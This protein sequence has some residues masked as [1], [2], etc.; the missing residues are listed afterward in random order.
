[1]EAWPGSP[2]PLGA[3]FDGA[4]TNFAIYSE[5]ADAIDLCLLD[6]L[7][8]ETR[9]PLADR[10]THVFHAYLPAVMPGQRYGFRVH[11]PNDP[12]MGHHC[13]P[14]R[15]LVDPYAKAIDAGRR[16][17]V[18][19]PFFDWGH[20]RPP[21]TPW[22]ETVIYELHVKGFT[23]LHPEVPEPLRGSYAGLGH[24]SVVEYLQKLGVTAVELL[25]VHQ[26]VHERFLRKKGLKNYWGYASIGYFAPHNEYASRG[27]DGQQVTEFKEMV[28]AF[29]RAGIEVILDVVYN[30]TG[31][32]GP[33]EPTH[34]FRGIDNRAYYR[35]DPHH[36]ERYVDYTG[37]GNSLNMRNPYVIQLIMDSL[38][39]WV[40]EMHVDGF[41]F[42][43]A[44]ALARELHEVNRLATFF[45]IIQQDPVL[46]QVKLIAEPWDLGEGGYQ[47]GN[48]P[49]AWSEWNGKYRDLVRDF[50]RGQDQTLGELAHRLTGSSDL[51]FGARRPYASIN[52]IT[53]HDGFTMRDL[54]S[55]EQKHNEANL[56]DNRDGTN[57]N[58]S[59]NCGVEGATDD[60]EILA[61]R[62][63][64]QRNFLATLFLSQGVPMMLA[65]DELSRTQHGNNNAYCQDS[66]ISW[67][68]WE[69]RDEDLRQFVE[70]LISLRHRHPVFQRRYWFQGASIRGDHLKD[71]GWFRPDGLEMNEQDW[72]VHYARALGVFLN[73]EGLRARD[74]RG[75]RIVDDSF[76]LILNGGEEGVDFTIPTTLLDGEGFRVEVDTNVPSTWGSEYHVGDTLAVGSRSVILLRRPR[77]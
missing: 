21:G 24:Y 65:G 52:F 14:S 33:D 10:T 29:H 13:D 15:L 57:D 50:W 17:L 75:R 48:F 68:D 63:R 4:G 69:S 74:A 7:G 23:Q 34:C 58:R 36:P 38:R 47:V 9:V 66:A 22:H 2:H 37:T 49:P 25:P 3:S 27:M 70:S 18:I 72:R 45:Q 39:Y 31:E 53:C 73:G 8:N 20:D 77:G 67:V 76:Y 30:H 71:I 64:Q 28:R 44:P 40:T 54:V 19:N 11:G 5:I 6:E 41:R 51:Y 35:V 56:E 26:F 43:L 62:A 32:G 12:A 16:S 42:D 59:W 61:L 46:S 1:M 60:P 55:Y